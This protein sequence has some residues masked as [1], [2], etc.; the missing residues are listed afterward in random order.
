M[1]Q[2]LG[3]E[4]ARGSG[5]VRSL[6]ILFF[7]SL[8]FNFM[9]FTDASARPTT[10][11]T[12]TLTSNAGGNSTLTWTTTT[13]VAPSVGPIRYDVYRK[14]VGGAFV[15]IGQQLTNG[16]P[17]TDT[18]G[19][20]AWENGGG[21][22]KDGTTFDATYNR[23][24]LSYQYVI[25]AID[26]ADSLTNT[27][28][29]DAT[30]ASVRLHW[31]DAQ[32]PQITTMTGAPVN[33]SK[34]RK[35]QFTI[36]V[37]A[38]F[39]DWDCN[40]VSQFNLRYS[41][42]ATT[43]TTPFNRPAGTVTPQAVTN[44]TATMDLNQAAFVDGNTI[45]YWIECSDP[46]GNNTTSNITPTMLASN[47]RTLIL[48]TVAPT[49]TS[50]TYMETGP[51]A[52]IDAGDQFIVTF[53]EDLQTGQGG[54]A[55]LGSTN[56]SITNADGNAGNFG[57][58]GSI[59]GGP[60]NTQVTM[61]LGTGPILKFVGGANSTLRYV[62]VTAIKDLAGNDADGT[63]VFTVR[64][65]QSGAP[66]GQF[67]NAP[68]PFINT[69]PVFTD[70]DNSGTVNASDK[71]LLTF[72]KPVML[73][74]ASLNGGDFVQAPQIITGDVF[75][76][77]SAALTGATN[78][79]IDITLAAGSN[80][81]I[82]GVYNSG[83]T[84]AGSPSGFDVRQN[85]ANTVPPNIVDDFGN[86]AQQR[87]AGSGG[88]VLDIIGASTQGPRVTS[89]EYN[90]VDNAGIRD[91][92]SAGDTMSV[93]FDK[94]V[95]LGN[96]ALT[97][98][99]AF[100]LTVGGDSLDNP[101]FA[102]SGGRLYM[103]Y[104]SA[105]I[106]T[107]YG[108]GAGSSGAD[109]SGSLNDLTIMDIYGNK[110]VASTS[111]D[112]GFLA[113]IPGPAI[114]TSG[115]DMIVYTDNA[116]AGV[117]SGDFIDIIFDK[118]IVLNGAVTA[119]DFNITS[120]NFG[121][122]PTFATIDNAAAGNGVN[123]RMLRATL[124]GSA[125]V[126]GSS[127]IGLA[128]GTRIQNWGGTGTV[129]GPQYPVRTTPPGP[130]IV[131]AAFTDVTND[132]ITSGD[133]IVLTF[134]KPISC[135]ATHVANII[136][137]P[138]A[139]FQLIRTVTN[140]ANVPSLGT[141][142]L[143]GIDAPGASGLTNQQI[144]IKLGTN[145]NLTIAGVF[146]TDAD[147]VGIDVISGTTNIEDQ[148]GNAAE[149]N[150]PAGKD[151]AGT[152]TTR[153]TLLSIAYTD[154]G[155]STAPFARLDGITGNPAGGGNPRLLTGDILTLTFDRAVT[156]SAAIAANA[157]RTPVNNDTL[158]TFTLVQPG[159]NVTTA[160][161]PV[162]A[163]TATQIRLSFT[164][165]PS[166]KVA[167]VYNGNI[168]A[169]SA[170]GIDIANAIP[171]GTITDVY[172]NTADV[173]T[174]KD[175]GTTDI[176]NPTPSEA[177]YIDVNNNGVDAGDIIRLGFSEPVLVNP[178]G[179]T[180]ISAGNFTLTNGGNLGTTGLLFRAFNT[181]TNNS[182]IEI[183]LGTGA[184]LQFTA[185]PATNSTIDVNDGSGAIQSLTDV[186]GLGAVHKSA[187]PVS[188]MPQSST[189]PVITSVTYT[190][191]TND[192]VSAG[193]TLLLTFS[194]N[195]NINNPLAQNFAIYGNNGT[196]TLGVN[197]AFATAG[198]AANQL[199]ITL[200]T[201]PR[202]TVVGTYSGP[203]GAATGININDGVAPN[204]ANPNPGAIF[205]NQNQPAVAAAVPIDIAGAS[206]GT[207]PQITKG[208]WGDVN[209]NG[210]VDA[211]DTLAITFNK[212]I[213]VP[214]PAPP[215]PTALTRTVFNVPVSGDYIDFTTYAKTGTYELTLTLSNLARFRV[216]GVYANVNTAGSPS[217]IDIAGGGI[218][219]NSITD[220]LGNLAVPS[221]TIT[222]IG[223]SDTT[224][225]VLV[226]ASY[227]DTNASNTVDTGDRVTLNFSEPIVINAPVK[228]NFNVQNGNFG[229][230][231]QFLPGGAN[232]QLIVQIDAG[233]ALTF[234]GAT[235][236]S[237]DINGTISTLT[238]VSGNFAHSSTQKFLTVQS[239]GNGPR[240]ITAQWIDNAPAGV[241]SAGDSLRLTFD[242]DIILNGVASPLDFTL[243]VTGDTLGV[244]VNIVGGGNAREI[245]VTLGTGAYLSIIGT[246]ASTAVT[247]NSPSGIDISTVGAA[248]GHIVDTF[249]FNARA[250]T[251]VGV[252]ITS[253][254]ATG[255]H[256]ITAVY[257]DVD[258][259]GVTVGDRVW[260]T[261]NE[262]VTAPVGLAAV[263][264][265]H[266]SLL[267][268]GIGNL[269]AN[270]S[271]EWY[272]TSPAQLIIKLGNS[273]ALTIKGV[274]PTTPGAN[275]IDVSGTIT[276]ITDISGNP[277]V[278]N[279]PA[280]VDIGPF[281]TTPPAV[282][283]C[284]Y[285][286]AN[287]SGA[288][289]QGDRLYAVFNE[290]VIMSNPVVTDFRLP[291]TNDTLGGGATF[292]PGNNNRE[293]MITL[294]S[295]PVLKP[296]GIFSPTALTP[297]APSGIDV[298]QPN[299][300]S[301]T[302]IYGNP[303][304]AS[305]GVDID[306][307]V[308]PSIVSAV[309]TDVNNNGIDKGDTVVLTFTEPI[310]ISNVVESDLQLPIPGDILGS[311]PAF[312]VAPTSTQLTITLGTNPVLL[313]AGTYL[314]TNLSAGSPSGINISATLANGHITDMALNNAIRTASAVDITG[315]DLVRPTL[316][317]A[318]WTDMNANGVDAG[319]RLTLHFD[320]PITFR[321][322]QP[323]DYNLP[324]TSDSLGFSPNISVDAV[325]KTNLNIL[326]GTAPKLTIPGVFNAGVTTAGSPSG[327]DISNN[328]TT[329][330]GITDVYGNAAMPSSV[331][332]ITG[333]DAAGPILINAVYYDTSNNGVSQ[334]DVLG[335]VF[336]KSL[337]I[338]GTSFAGQFVIP[339]PG[340][341]LGVGATFAA[342]TTAADIRVTL[343]LN[344]FLTIAGTYTSSVL[345]A[346]SPSGIGC[347][348]TAGALS[349]YSGNPPQ[350]TDPVDIITA[351]LAGPQL[352]IARI[353]DANG[354]NF[355]SAGDRMVL[356]FN[357]PVKIIPPGLTV[358]DFVLPVNSDTFGANAT[359]EVNMLNSTEV[360][361]G[362]Q[363]G[364]KFRVDGTFNAATIASGSP[365]GIA[366]RAGCAVIQDFI[367][368]MVVGGTVVDIAD[369]F[370]PYVSTVRFEDV[371]NNGINAG[372]RLYVKFSE[373]IVTANLAITDF[374][375]TEALDSFGDL[376]GVIQSDTDMLIITL[377]R[378]AKFKIAGIY[379]ADAGSS[380]LDLSLNFV[381]DH[382]KDSSSNSAKRT[383]PKDIY[384]TD[385][386]RPVITAARYGDA[387]NNGRID[388]GD[389][390]S[391][392]FSKAIVI[393][394]VDK[395]DFKIIN[396][397]FGVGGTLAA[398]Q[399][400][401][402]EISFVL[403]NAPT[404]VVE[405]VYPGDPN[406]TAIDLADA[407]VVSH[408]SDIVGNSPSSVGYIDISDVSGP[409][410]VSAT[411]Y[412]VNAN[413]VSQ[414]DQ[415]RI[416]FS[417]TIVVA[418]P[419]TSTFVLPVNGDTFG[420][421]PTISSSG[422]NEITVTLGGAPQLTIAGTFLSGNTAPSSPSGVNINGTTSTITDVSGNPARSLP[423]AVDITGSDLVAPTLVSAIYTDVDGNGVSVNDKITL[424][425]SENM[426]FSNMIS[427]ADFQ[428]LNGNFGDGVKFAAG[429]SGRELIVTLG[430]NALFSMFGAQQTAIGRH[431]STY[432]TG[433]MM[434]IS[435]NDWPSGVPVLV[436]SND[437][438]A[439]TIAGVKFV[440]AD[441]MG[442]TRGDRIEVTFNKAVIVD[443]TN[444]RSTDFVLPVS[445]DSFGA[446][447]VVTAMTDKKAVAIIL[448]DGANFTVRG[449]FSPGLLATNSPSGVN[450]SKI[451]TT[452]TSLA[453]IGAKPH[454]VAI[455]I[456]SDDMV[457]PKIV[458]AESQGAHGKNII[459]ARGDS[460]TL[461][462][463]IDD[464]SLRAS[465]ITADLR[466]FG[467]GKA[468][469][470][471]SYINGTA[472]WASINTP[473]VRGTIEVVVSAIDIAG[474]IGT[475]GLYVS[476]IMP[477]EKVGAEITPATV[478]RKSGARD[479]KMLLNPRFRSYDTGM[480]K[481]VITVPKGSSAT[482][483]KTNF[484]NVD[485]S[486]GTVIINGRLATTRF[487]GTPNGGEVVMTYDT[488][489]SEITILLGERVNQNTTIQTI[490]VNF[491]A[492]VPEFEDDPFGKYFA[493]KVDDTKDPAAV[494]ATAENVNQI[495]GDSDGLKV[496]TMGIKVK[497]V[498][499]KVVIT[500]SFW[501]VV[502]SIKFNFDM[503]AEKPPKV[504]FKP[505]YTLQNEQTVTL[506]SFVDGLY[507]GYAIVPFEAFGFNGEYLL[508]VY[509][510]QDYMGNDVNTL[511][512]RQKFS[513]KFLI[514]AFMN[515]LDEKT[516]MI[517]TKYIQS[518]TTEVLVS[519]PT[520]R[521]W[522]D[523]TNE[524][525]LTN[526][527]AVA[528]PNLY[529]GFY[530]IS[531]DYSG[532]AQI[533]V[534]GR[535]GPDS[536]VINGKSVV[537][538]Q[539]QFIK[540]DAGGTLASSD[541]KLNMVIPKG[542]FD[543]DVT[544]VLLP[545][546]TKISQMMEYD[547]SENKAPRLY[548]AAQSAELT[549]MTEIFRVYPENL[550]SKL[551]IDVSCDISKYSTKEIENTGL[552]T[553]NAKSGMWEFASKEV[554]NGRMTAKT[555]GVS[556]VA[557][558]KDITPPALNVP[559][560][561]FDKVISDKFDVE[562]TDRGS[563]LD[564]TSIKATLSGRLMKTEYN[565][566]DG[567]L[568]LYIPGKT[569]AGIHNVTLEVNDRL[570]N[571]LSAPDMQVAAAGFFDIVN[572][573]SYPNPA[574]SRLN[575]SYTL[576][577]AISELNIKIYDAN[578]DMVYDF[579]DLPMNSF[580]AGKHTT[581]AWF[582]TNDN[583]DRV[584][585]GVY[586]YKMT[587]RDAN[588]DKLEKYGK[589]AILK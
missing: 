515:P 429:T 16:G 214:L 362:L 211:G 574:K 219:P 227:N 159:D 139:T 217:G 209:N 297:G 255:P 1:L 99:S 293:V 585:N 517:N 86:S 417:R 169:G 393:N 409:V 122:G 50:I 351:S 134:D 53:S 130:K 120:L 201:T 155:T 40:S 175:I 258:T 459:K 506:M 168:V 405:G 117:S 504:T 367:G 98:G 410:I 442:I 310:Q 352:L 47:P 582:L 218:T 284:R 62:G 530:T 58:G 270:P 422:S 524:T 153:P 243:P 399:I 335:L 545:D 424:T 26:N 96:G 127:R 109:I 346:G 147:A 548:A 105:P 463:L 178:F 260:L 289:D 369:T 161:L 477:V 103:N 327:I 457:P 299:I 228:A 559:K 206:G 239:A 24:G 408:I 132:G 328:M 240:I 57:S 290:T 503:N 64:N 379:P 443:E 323:A 39:V 330:N 115:T 210:V 190:D 341:S 144:R 30:T 308:G 361:V 380:G 481:I 170:S 180:P 61:V 8:C 342:G 377:G 253:N 43:I 192:G 70:S 84:T 187:P 354:D 173:S 419:S 286:D 390:L 435:G 388:A 41:N 59:V 56:F 511:T 337:Q 267:P 551:P 123:R 444:A 427:L 177:V 553:M 356:T 376:A 215:P 129:A 322:Y 266:F 252:D 373:Q 162:A 571:K 338:T 464:P 27:D 485:I 65:N 182:T 92:L 431:P 437:T 185:N 171:A 398:S 492:T 401:T 315:S 94:P 320:K 562:L 221:S 430:N 500:P 544:L 454:P 233:A 280:G 208:S 294:G 287:S 207:G 9:F 222:D 23:F 546:F 232:T 38:N 375:L 384:S 455:D 145:P 296:V 402:N 257:E 366:I 7:I 482:T 465:D 572:F 35:T 587:A 313:I 326:L 76:V 156:A 533:E 489:T 497:Y 248:S 374:A 302:D 229:N 202:L 91:G 456:T 150:A 154:T 550:A 29:P 183:V 581:P 363:T 126:N 476:V 2:R 200:G 256:I 329:T 295:A 34:Q 569:M 568:T 81:T 472:T 237:V 575:I 25:L 505:T 564:I 149:A 433:H 93:V 576:G 14:P 321:S 555:N 496:T 33:A 484:T 303:A 468:V 77:T 314:P 60:L 230:A 540:S 49:I 278:P 263:Q 114:K 538:F 157:F 416:K 242:K 527:N 197:P 364:V 493:V 498:T 536:T 358:T 561:L 259:N 309:Y 486:K 340:D 397:S 106:L 90:D 121:S 423:S 44:L 244:G 307:G 495:T 510:A 247:P 250:N 184:T 395:N 186:S 188:I 349:D 111:K 304:T 480:D 355:I 137:N 586:F 193:D 220:T 558:F 113:T 158:A 448:G 88:P 449:Q 411:Y 523:G 491:R 48:D 67:P 112:I 460:I 172:G 204:P 370:A 167:G 138:A 269:G 528:R 292:G 451:L 353:D 348:G 438:V 272:A 174:P 198:L 275:G 532:K 487:N 525:L 80:F 274:Y 52:G 264:A 241:V 216:D 396:G 518:V 136:A 563:G 12:L 223:S 288:V 68:R 119:A 19:S 194:R 490:E 87:P 445:G 507:M 382:I 567:K 425:F 583:G 378:N 453:G 199:R 21:G 281:E 151:L 196:D 420:T 191:V 406:A 474:N 560:D 386:T 542:A 279:A 428:L 298:N 469:A 131:T 331:K 499:D 549:P 108:T 32:A 305:A 102:V 213:V 325:D 357:K 318:R 291:V 566:K 238:D 3:K 513:P 128:A 234:I 475:Y 283:G 125:I 69:S 488:T 324:V 89:F 526:V 508:N 226:S 371:G 467:L 521:V 316:L 28:T 235:T 146:G 268:A 466:S 412:D 75:N 282:I 501:K 421:S 135:D 312:T 407:F 359:Y 557:V 152:V 118:P 18:I 311:G 100:N 418:A 78:N 11:P 579:G 74:T 520:I 452:I 534:E 347:N 231:P 317:T 584:A 441:N 440:D 45:S 439:P 470:A 97:V 271:F 176:V 104:T 509:N 251:P 554:K 404:L 372:D 565:E 195:I 276:Q 478:L 181:N 79:Q 400:G 578:A 83:T 577:K 36:S 163:L 580:S 483:D 512:V 502:F 552:F 10:G 368:N 265:A 63:A 273:P 414:G 205:D 522:Q 66:A 450:L 573:V 333:G 301:I 415:L 31:C 383:T 166:I 547:G 436:S 391:V 37:G 110:A 54:Q 332:D 5:F 381:A 203:T 6:L 189:G 224:G 365:S 140:P 434:D 13:P 462:A 387:N 537:E 336:D 344:P 306:D 300:T 277:S 556:S 432:V 51:L 285:V 246:Y 447:A 426:L 261:F 236:S 42:G 160:I 461:T 179:T 212:A 17:V 339:I 541:A 529:K 245:V 143:A 589:I 360:F 82:A 531:P 107:V 124:G 403:G 514:S 385:T 46:N 225:P 343:G 519:N 413:G 101:T 73:Y 85:A 142:P 4:P 72:S 133:T 249:G 55:A 345:L 95:L 516:L 71:L 350:A 458:S 262:N 148:I 539:S 446:G 254:D 543:R 164:A 535:V 319:D 165:A 22:A 15:R 20:D 141:A 116:P 473:D 334:G 394:G 479:F 588:G 389:T 570:G 471:Q 494:S 392:V